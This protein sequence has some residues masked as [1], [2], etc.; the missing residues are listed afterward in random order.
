M[1]LPVQLASEKKLS[2]QMPD[3]YQDAPRYPKQGCYQLVN[4]S[5]D[6][7]QREEIFQQEYTVVSLARSHHLIQLLTMI[8][9]KNLNALCQK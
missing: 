9:T 5:F 7:K 4:H 3:S 6:N 2:C 1:H 8:T